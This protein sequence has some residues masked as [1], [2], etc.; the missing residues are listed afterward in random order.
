[1]RNSKLKKELEKQDLTQRDLAFKT[2]ISESTVCIIVRH[3]RMD[4][5]EH[6]QIIADILKVPEHEIFPGW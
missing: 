5:P 2:G 1:M 6:R 3:G 4:T